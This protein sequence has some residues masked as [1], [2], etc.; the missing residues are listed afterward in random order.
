MISKNTE[1]TSEGQ[2]ANLKGLPLA[3]KSENFSL[4]R[5]MNAVGW[6]KIY[7]NTWSHS[8]I[9]NEKQTRGQTAEARRT[10]NLQPVEG[11]PHSQK[12][13]Q[14]EKAEDFVPDKE[15]R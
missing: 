12:D 4:R 14:N 11:K 1:V 6:N 9:Q 8:D 7:K 15:T 10:T 13:T 3:K 5:I 2:A